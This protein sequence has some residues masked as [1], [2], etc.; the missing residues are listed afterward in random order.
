MRAHRAFAARLESRLSL[1]A[2]ESA[3]L[4][5]LRVQAGDRLTVFDGAGLEADATAAGWD[6]DRLLLELGPPRAAS[7]E[8]PRPLLLVVALL[9]ADKLADVVRAATELGVAAFQPLVAARSEAREVG[10]VKLERWRR[11]ALEAARQSGRSLRPEVRDPMPVADLPAV[12]CGIVAHPGAGA[13]AREL[14]SWD[15]PLVWLA[16]GP[17]GGFTEAE[18]ELLGERGYRAAGLGPRI[19]RAETAPLALLAAVAAGEGV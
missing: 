12:E 11:I 14:V 16:T 5:V 7:R 18:V 13:R 10:A 4:R 3:H 15:A 9:K 6:G 8:T 19:L 2:A 1:S 17:E